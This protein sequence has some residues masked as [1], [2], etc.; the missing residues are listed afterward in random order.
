MDEVGSRPQMLLGLKLGVDP[1]CD[2]FILKLLQFCEQLVAFLRRKM[3]IACR[4]GWTSR[5]CSGPADLS[6]RG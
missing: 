1:D 4:R 6:F 3:S 2:Q 5:G